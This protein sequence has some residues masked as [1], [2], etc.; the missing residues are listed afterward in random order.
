MPIRAEKVNPKSIDTALEKE[1]VK[2]DNFTEA[3]KHLKDSILG[4]ENIQ[5]LKSN[6]KSQSQ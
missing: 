3:I 1:L 5:S 6:K 2:I 4:Q